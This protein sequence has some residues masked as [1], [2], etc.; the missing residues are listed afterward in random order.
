M[1]SHI[2]SRPR[3]SF[4]SQRALAEVLSLL[5]KDE[6]E[7]AS[8]RA[9]LKRKRLWREMTGFVMK[10]GLPLKNV[11]LDP[12]AL[13]WASWSQ[14]GGFQS[15]WSD[16]ASRHAWDPSHLWDICLCVDEVSLGNQLKPSNE[17]KLQ[18]I[19]FSVKRFGK[20]A[21]SK[22]DAW[23]VLP[24]VRSA[25]VKRGEDGMAQGMK[26]ILRIYLLERRDALLHGVLLPFPNNQKWT[27]CCELG[28]PILF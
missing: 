13:L 27:L 20:L 23:W 17:R 14:E 25:D 3:K 21:L 9:A 19:Y 24:A 28:S 16:M 5:P 22:E 10:E 2:L 7:S 26:K 8:S 15:F 12:I 11:S 4:I 18:V 6:Q 1:A